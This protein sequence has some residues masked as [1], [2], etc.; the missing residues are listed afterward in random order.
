M[1]LKTDIPYICWSVLEFFIPM[2]PMWRTRVEPISRQS[3]ETRIQAWS[4][5]TLILGHMAIGAGGPRKGY[6]SLLSTNDYRMHYPAK[7][8]SSRPSSAGSSL[9]NK[10][11]SSTF[12]SE[13]CIPTTTKLINTSAAPKRTWARAGRPRTKS[14][15]TASGIVKLRPI[16]TTRGVVLSM[17]RTY[18]KSLESVKPI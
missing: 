14:P 7:L 17:A 1:K 13:L 15:T 4:E 16:V 12:V 18:M 2:H 8:C 5:T 3:Y 11:L 10:S 9:S 6:K